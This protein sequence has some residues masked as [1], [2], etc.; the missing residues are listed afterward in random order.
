MAVE[1]KPETEQLVERE[2]QSG[3]FHSIDELIA[4]SL[5]AWHEKHPSEHPAPAPLHRRQG[6]KSLAQLF[7]ES[8]FRGLEM[9]FER[10][11]DLLPPVDL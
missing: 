9:N 4:E 1:L 6:N 2:L 3:H 7:A 5:S 10:F 11:P 8:P